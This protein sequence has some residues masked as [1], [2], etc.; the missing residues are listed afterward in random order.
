MSDIVERRVSDAL[1]WAHIEIERSDSQA[2]IFNNMMA[3][4]DMSPIVH[5]ET[6]HLRALV[7]EITRL[8]SQSDRMRAEVVEA[9]AK[10]ADEYAD[11]A[12]R[13]LSGDGADRAHQCAMAIA[14]RI[15]SLP[16]PPQE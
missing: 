7:A 10:V 16:K 4:Y 1:N 9:C 15:R 5:Q 14:S 11:R 6:E 13:L 8:R 3:K 12:D 2:Q